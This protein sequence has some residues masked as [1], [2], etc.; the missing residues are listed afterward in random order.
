MLDLDEATGADPVTD[1]ARLLSQLAMLPHSMSLPAARTRPPARAFV[2]EYFAHVPGSWHGRLPA[3]YAL[4]LIRLIP[5]LFRRS[6]TDADQK[7]AQLLG[8]ARQALAGDLW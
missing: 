1:V 8:E 2:E 3:Q 6:A 4:A 5:N 7:A